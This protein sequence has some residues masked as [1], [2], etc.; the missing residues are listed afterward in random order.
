MKNIATTI[1]IILVIVT[2]LLLAV[3]F[4]VRQTETALVTR[5]GKAVRTIEEPGL[6]FRWPVPIERV[7]KFDRR[8]RLFEAEIGETTTRGAVP[9]I[10]NTF[11]I[12]QIVDPLQFFNAVGSVEQA[13]IKLLSQI[14]D[15]QNRVIG[16]HEFSEFVN[17][18]PEKIK[19]EKIQSEILA[20]LSAPA[21][22]NYGIE[23][24]TVGIK[25]LKVNEDTTKDVFE[26]MRAERERRTLATI[27][28]GT[29]LATAIKSDADKKNQ[30]L[31]AAADARAK[32]IRGQGDA[33]AAR[34]YE[35]LRDDPLFAIF[36]RNTEALKKILE[37]R[38][39]IVFSA[40]TEPFKLLK[41]IP[42][43]EPQQK[44]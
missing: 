14:Q 26:R 8:M 40:D 39:T 20:G 22:E 23:I 10:V 29:A 13:E 5:F 9:I 11:V 27:S 7:H 35:L 41:E 33:E 32:A 43:L 21:R 37:K 30:L 18:D 1:L 19:F 15:S 34:Y 4:Q 17:S 12:W 16:R 25:Q 38:S 36:L 42:E 44:N 6:K 28:E 2:G 24:K 31:L 3:C